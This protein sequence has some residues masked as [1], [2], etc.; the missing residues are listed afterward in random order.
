MLQDLAPNSLIILGSKTNKIGRM[1]TTEKK[2]CG[3]VSFT[4]YFKKNML[5]KINYLEHIY[6]SLTYF[7]IF[8]IYLVFIN[9]I[10]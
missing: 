8:V 9:L 5:I 2:I 10:I 6:K 4:S 1:V 3:K 7:F